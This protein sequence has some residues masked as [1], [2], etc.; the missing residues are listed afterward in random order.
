[1]GTCY[2]ILYN[3]ETSG[4]YKHGTSVSVTGFHDCGFYVN[5]DVTINAL[6]NTSADLEVINANN[7]LSAAVTSGD[8][9]TS[10]TP[11][12]NTRVEDTNMKVTIKII[13]KN[14]VIKTE[15]NPLPSTKP[16]SV[17]KR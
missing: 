17:V 7:S 3:T 10:G 4:F 13:A 12:I 16:S 11:D 15:Y 2:N 14:V 6:L 9:S 5:N 1:M 8:Q